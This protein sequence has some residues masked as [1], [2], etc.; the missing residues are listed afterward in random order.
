MNDLKE[1]FLRYLLID[2]GYSS[3]TIESYR[4]DLEKFVKFYSNKSIK[5]ITNEDLKKYIKHLNE[6]GLNEKSIS[7]NVSC[8]KSFYKFLVIEKFI[9]N[10]VSDSLFLP[11]IRKALPNILTEEEVLKLLDITPTLEG[12][13]YVVE[14]SVPAGTKIEKGMSLTL[15]LAKKF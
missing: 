2:K 4:N 10:N 12:S 1:E 15:K 11:K 14:Q 9:T 8:L 3:N 5:D 13:G 7:R 6:E